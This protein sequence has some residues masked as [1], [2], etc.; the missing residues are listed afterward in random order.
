MPV[1]DEKTEPATVEPPT[2]PPSS[3][4]PDDSLIGL[5]PELLFHLFTFLPLCDLA[6]FSS[7]SRD[8]HTLVY[9]P[10]NDEAVYK[11]RAAAV[12]QPPCTLV[13]GRNA[14]QTWLGVLKCQLRSNG[15]RNSWETQESW[16][17]PEDYQ[18]WNLRSTLRK[19]QWCRLATLVSEPMVQLYSSQCKS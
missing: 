9:G 2:V 7:C 10:G 17:S 8:C 16:I 3:V 4:L 19:G 13:G 18:V 15:M 11:T 1:I 5:A 6:S 14:H 12:A